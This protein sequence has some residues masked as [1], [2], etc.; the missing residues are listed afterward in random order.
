MWMSGNGTWPKNAFRASH[1]RTVLSLPIDHSIPSC[2]KARIGLAQDVNAPV[3]EAVEVVHRFGPHEACLR[4]MPRCSSNPTT[5][6]V[7]S[8]GG[9]WPLSRRSTAMSPAALSLDL[10]AAPTAPTQSVTISVVVE[11]RRTSRS[12]GPK[13]GPGHENDAGVEQD[14]RDFGEARQLPRDVPQEVTDA[15]IVDQVRL[16]ALGD[17]LS[18]EI[19]VAGDQHERR[20]LPVFWRAARGKR[21]SSPRRR[22][23]TFRSRREPWCRPTLRGRCRRRR[24]RS[25]RRERSGSSPRDRR[26]RRRRSG[27]AHFRMHSATSLRS[28]RAF[29]SNAS[30]LE[31]SITRWTDSRRTGT[32]ALP[33]FR[34]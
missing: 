6:R 25:R 23:S 26:P 11:A 16:E 20:F 22:S 31:A 29:C 10:P 33:S 21:R 3:F 27:C 30:R 13:V 17:R 34:M 24:S 19:A 15:T 5:A 28:T 12:R 7:A 32:R 2:L 9:S 4:R 14:A 1:K 8:S 18:I